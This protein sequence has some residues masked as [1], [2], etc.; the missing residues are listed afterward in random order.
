MKLTLYPITRSGAGRL[1]MMARPR[2][3]AWLFDELHALRRIG[4]EVLVCA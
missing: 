1:S 3:G 2:G 4:V